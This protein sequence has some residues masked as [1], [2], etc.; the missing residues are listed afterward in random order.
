MKKLIPVFLLVALLLCACAGPA[1][2]D[3]GPDHTVIT[4]HDGSVDI[5]GGGAR[6]T[7]STVTI[8]AAG[9]YEVTGSGNGDKPLVIDTGDDAMDVTVILNNAELICL[10]GPA[11]HVCQAKNF[12]LQLAA[13]S[14]NVLVSGT[15]E[16]LQ[17]PDP[18]ASGA[19]LFS[20]DDMDIEGN[21]SLTV[22]GYINNGIACKND[23]DLNSGTITVVA[24]NNGVRG[25]DSVQIKGGTL[26]VTAQGDGIKSA[27]DDKEGKGY[28]EI[29][30]GN[31]IVEAWGDGI[32]A[33]TELRVSGG[34][35][36]VTA[37]GDGMEQSSKALK[38]EKDVVI[39]GGNLV[40]NAQEDGIRS[41]TGNVILSGGS[42]EICALADGIK[43]GEKDSGLGDIRISGGETLIFAGKHG[44]K[45]R[46]LF[47]MS[48][49][50]LTAL[51]GSDK[52]AA[53]AEGVSSALC[54][55]EGV[56][57]DRI[58][59]GQESGGLEAKLDYRCLL[60]AD[61]SLNPGESINV[62][63][64]GHSTVVIVA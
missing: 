38:A 39:S 23:L 32:Q 52:Q 54:K 10:S 42:L 56:A 51:C 63:G 6:D 60:Y 61:G 47:T 27:T 41:T 43:A 11:I 31:V 55:L 13:G 45:A 36:Q 2:T 50:R 48:A 4:F 49:G 62:T 9:T 5:Q 3:E 34:A 8:S 7:G 24:A 57:G 22:Y 14:E 53:P 1:G 21:G 19:A 15:E 40:L 46:G 12:R 28:V 58:L 18:N 44:L 26:T 25:S 64:G 20:E 33:A 16:L 35:V 59:I 17:T 30:G 37:L 29:A